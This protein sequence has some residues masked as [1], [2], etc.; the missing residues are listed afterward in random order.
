MCLTPPVGCDCHLASL[1]LESCAWRST[2]G[3]AVAWIPF[4]RLWA[5]HCHPTPALHGHPHPCTCSE[6]ALEFLGVCPALVD[7]LYAPLLGVGRHS[8]SVSGAEVIPA[9]THSQKTVWP[10]KMQRKLGMQAVFSSSSSSALGWHLSIP[11]NHPGDGLARPCMT[12][13]ITGSQVVGSKLLMSHPE[14]QLG[15]FSYPTFLHST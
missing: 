10:E 13:R 15:P 1:Q 6:A 14:T 5:Y 9:C 12:N 2:P 7:I 4:F 3:W 8:L 11:H